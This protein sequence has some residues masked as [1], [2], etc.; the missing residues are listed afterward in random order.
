MD[1]RSDSVEVRRVCGEG[2]SMTDERIKQIAEPHQQFLDCKEMTLR[3]DGILE[4]ARALLAEGKQEWRA[5]LA[6]SLCRD[7]ERPRWVVENRA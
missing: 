3:G 5:E 2:K 6:E 1:A 4:F 7:L